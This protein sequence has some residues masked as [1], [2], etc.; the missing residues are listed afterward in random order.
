MFCSILSAIRFKMMLLCEGDNFPQ[1]GAAACA[2][3]SA[4]LILVISSLNSA[5]VVE[6]NHLL[7]IQG[8]GS[9]S[10]GKNFAVNW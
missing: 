8:A 3:S 6:L 7:D 2:E 9:S 10:G 5:C 1:D 4:A